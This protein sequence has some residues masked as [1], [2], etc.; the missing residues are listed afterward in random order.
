M[1]LKQIPQPGKPIQL[2]E[3]LLEERRFTAVYF[4]YDEGR[5]VYVGQS[6]TLKYRIDQ[7]IQDGTKIF[8]SV[9]F[10]RCCVSQLSEIE[11]YY[12]RAHAP[13]YNSCAIATKA[14]ERRKWERDKQP[15]YVPG[16]EIKFVDAAECIIPASELGEFLMVTDRDANEWREAGEITDRSI[17]GLIHFVARNSRKVAKAQDYFEQI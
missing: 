4:L 8:D 5:L 10:I 13:K 11:S 17:I 12:I 6:K 9:A 3:F 15:V 2:G 16:Q 14:K 1:A 7:H